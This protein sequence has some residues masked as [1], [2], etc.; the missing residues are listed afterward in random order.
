MT[1]GPPSWWLYALVMCL[2]FNGVPSPTWLVMA[3][4]YVVGLWV[5]PL[6]YAAWL[7]NAS[8]NFCYWRWVIY[9]RG[10]RNRAADYAAV[11][12]RRWR[13]GVGWRRRLLGWLDAALRRPCSWWHVALIRLVPVQ[14]SG[15]VIVCAGLPTL[16]FWPFVLGNALATIATTV[17]FSLM[18]DA[19][20][21]SRMPGSL[22]ALVYVVHLF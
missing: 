16:R 6:M 20:K 11:V 8:W 4:V 7:V 15:T 18:V 17:Y 5:A 19:V 3:S 9:Y 12:E 22:K 2:H 1:Y 21:A 13:A 14:A 10:G